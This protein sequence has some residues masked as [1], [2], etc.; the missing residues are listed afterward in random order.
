VKI[1]VMAIAVAVALGPVIAGGSVMAAG[2][3]GARAGADTV[4]DGDEAQFVGLVNQLR[5]SKG[6][7]ALTVNARLTSEA[8]NWAAEMSVTSM[9]HNPNIVAEA[10]PGWTV[11][12]E[13][14]G[15]G[16]NVSGLENAFVNS[17]H[18]YENLV[19]PRFN[20]IGVGVVMAGATMWVTQEFMAGPM[21]G[22]AGPAPA[23]VAATPRPTTPVPTPPRATT[24]VPTTPPPTAPPP[25][26][27]PETAAPKSTTPDGASVAGL[28]RPLSARVAMVFEQLEALDGTR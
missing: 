13:N 16:Q 20:Q 15:Y 23:A 6:A 12:G 21:G 3:I 2:A 24:S 19:D 9:H 4:T 8:R 26:T 14:V 5:L 7:Q 18:H 25:T 22:S 27:P 10:P 1:R 11:L 28:S 17:P